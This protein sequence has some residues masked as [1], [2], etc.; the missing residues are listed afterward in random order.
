MIIN[1]A[2]GS[3]GDLLPYM[4]RLREIGPLV[5]TRTWGGL[6]GIWDVPRLI[7]G[8]VI[9]APRGGF[10]DLAGEW[11]VENEGVAPDIEVEQLPAEVAAGRDPQLEK[12]VAVALE[13]L[14]T[15]PVVLKPQPPDPVRVRRP[16]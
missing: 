13:L 8:G 9:T 16:E 4:F 1:D 5:G 11:S 15:E 12:A 3:G 10:F 6:V 2:A 7:D 14:E